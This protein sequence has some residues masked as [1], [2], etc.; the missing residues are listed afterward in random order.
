MIP[1]GASGED[2][3]F[4]LRLVVATNSGG[5]VFYH[6]VHAQR[7]KYDC[8]TCH[9][10]WPR[11]ATAPLKFG[12]GGHES[13]SKMR[14]SCGTCHHRGGRAFAAEGNCTN[15]CHSVG[16]GKTNSASTSAEG[17]TAR[18]HTARAQ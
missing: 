18:V 11:D 7:E 4:P 17:K 16:A 6:F 2:K 10:E 9:R 5:V 13:A 1:N 8:Q 14:T 12:T 3:P 15:R